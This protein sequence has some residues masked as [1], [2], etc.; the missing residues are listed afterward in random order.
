M[1]KPR[2]ALLFL[3]ATPYYHCVSRCVRRA[4]LYDRDA[5]T[6]QDFEHRHQ[7]IVDKLLTLAGIFAMDVCAYAVLSNHYHVVM[8]VDREQAEIW[9]VTEVIQ[10]WHRLF[11]G[12]RLSQCFLQQAELSQ[13]E[14]NELENQV[15]LWQ[16][17]LMDL[18]WYMRVANESIARAANREDRYTGRFN[19]TFRN[20]CC[21]FVFHG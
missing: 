8:H 1:P 9:S 13:A 7:S 2:K 16:Q 21:C 14:R 20:L 11:S 12:S 10:R 18:S 17:R 5:V 6:G 19:E 15:N 4:F 3:D